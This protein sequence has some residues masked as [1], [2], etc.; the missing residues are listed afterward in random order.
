MDAE[1]YAIYLLAEYQGLGIGKRLLSE[2]VQ[3][4]KKQGVRSFIL[5]VLEGNEKAEKFYR[6]FSPDF[7]CEK[8][9]LF[10]DIS[11]N[12]K[13]YGWSHLEGILHPSATDSG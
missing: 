1:L 9:I 8:T 5:F 7:E 4:M 12:E 3:E 2:T 11:Y 13:G 6:S 10:D